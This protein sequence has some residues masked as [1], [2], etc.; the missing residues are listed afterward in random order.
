MPQQ[1]LDLEKCNRVAKAL[2]S[3]SVNILLICSGFSVAEQSER[4]ST[5]PKNFELWRSLARKGGRREIRKLVSRVT[6]PWVLYVSD[7]M[8]W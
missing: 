8:R 4:I 7:W 3:Q 1:L 2:E 5:I 6:A